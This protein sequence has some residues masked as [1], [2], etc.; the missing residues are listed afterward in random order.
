M[1][2]PTLDYTEIGTSGIST[3]KI[4]EQSVVTLTEMM[5]M[6][7]EGIRGLVHVQ[8]QKL[9]KVQSYLVLCAVHHH[10]YN[11]YR[12]HWSDDDDEDKSELALLIIK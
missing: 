1:I 12:P 3:K 11:P 8:H 6:T 10:S 2:R 9:P 5:M 4:P 7:R